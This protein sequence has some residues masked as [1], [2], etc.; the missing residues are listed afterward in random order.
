MI[1][2]EQIK[3]L[4]QWQ[5][6]CTKKKSEPLSVDS[7]VEVFTSEIDLELGWIKN[8]LKDFVD[9]VTVKYWKMKGTSYFVALQ[10][11]QLFADEGNQYKQIN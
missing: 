7:T 1:T 3:D 2:T 8:K 6:A 5:I 9:F 11:C 4:S 10:K